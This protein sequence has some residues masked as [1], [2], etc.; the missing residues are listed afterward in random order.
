M[1]CG[2]V[3]RY[4]FNGQEKSDEIKG[5]G[6]SYTA[7]FWEY[8]PRIG[9]RWNLDPKPTTG[10]SDYSV[11]Y[12]SPILFSDVLGNK[13]EDPP[14][15][16]KGLKSAYVNFMWWTGRAHPDNAAESFDITMHGLANA[17]LKSWSEIK[18]DAKVGAGNAYW[19]FWGSTN[20]ALKQ[21][22][23]GIYSKSP[24]DYNLNADQAAYFQKASD[25]TQNAP[26]L[27]MEGGGGFSPKGAL[28]GSGGVALKSVTSVEVKIA[29]TVFANSASGQ[30][31]QQQN[32]SQQQAP[33]VGFMTVRKLRRSQGLQLNRRVCWPDGMNF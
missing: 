1:E 20:G 4:G 31:Q 5:E 30:Q 12:N 6:N 23:F 21:L 13:P 19:S 28:S 10:V 24:G 25:F 29:T 2:E 16:Y 11:F 33:A 26:L 32:S 22:T 8:D 3:Y 17:H 7:Q 9:R 27:P 14:G 15:W 18:S